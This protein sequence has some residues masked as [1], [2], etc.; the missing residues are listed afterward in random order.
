MENIHFAVCVKHTVTPAM[1]YFG[2]AQRGRRMVLVVLR[3]NENDLCYST[4]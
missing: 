1:Y 2:Q 4:K 3:E